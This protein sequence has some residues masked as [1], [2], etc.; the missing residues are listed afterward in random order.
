MIAELGLTGTLALLA[1][2][3][4]GLPHGAMDAAVALSLGYRGMVRLLTFLV[5]Y[6]LTALAVV[7]FWLA[8]PQP[9]ACP[10]PADQHGAF[11]AG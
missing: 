4:I 6:T 3:V 9:V 5:V 7:M 10:L 2:V 8:F 11:R 1:V